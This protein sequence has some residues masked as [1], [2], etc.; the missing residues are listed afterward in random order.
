MELF[1]FL[2][3]GFQS[4]AWALMWLILIV[5]FVFL[6]LFI[7]RCYYLFLVCDRGTAP[8]MKNLQNFLKAADFDRAVKLASSEKTPLA[9]GVLAI[10][11]NRQNGSKAVRKAVDEVFLAEG[12]RVK[13][14]IFLLNTMANVATL[15]G[16]TGTI[17]GTMECFNSIANIPAAQRAQALANGISITMSATLMGLIV[18]VP[19][20]IGH[21]LCSAKA[22][23]I[24]EDLDEKLTKLS[25]ALEE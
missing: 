20:V 21:G 6:A 4:S 19:C 23:K 17:Y 11:Q 3:M 22:D 13:R 9:K 16:L 1:K 12:P 8:F 7:E 10:L 14:N 18:A 24:V 2:G 5:G 15:I 25:N